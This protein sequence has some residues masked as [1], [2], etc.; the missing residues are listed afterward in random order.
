[1]SSRGHI[2]AERAEQEAKKAQGRTLYT[3]STGNHQGLIVDENTGENVAVTY[4]KKDD[5]ELVK[6]YNAFPE[7]LAALE[8]LLKATRKAHEIASASNDDYADNEAHYVGEWMDEAREA[9]TNATK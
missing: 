9:I 1:M 5:E 2:Q 6:R 3:S 7:L 4:D 8:G